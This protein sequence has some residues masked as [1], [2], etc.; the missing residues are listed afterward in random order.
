MKLSIAS[1]NSGSNGNCYY[2]GNQHEAVLIDAGISCRET[3]WRM[4]QIG[5]SINRV[6]AIFISHEHT[7]HTRG[8]EVLAR[9]YKIP[10]YFSDITYQNSRIKPDERFVH[11][12][13]SNIPVVIG[14]LTV[15][16]FPKR[17][18]ASDAHSFIVSGNEVHIGVF[19]DIGSVCENVKY[20]FNKCHAAFLEANYDEEMLE[21]GHYPYYLKTRIRSDYGHLSNIQALELF[22]N[23]SS[24]K[25]VHLFLSH[26]SKDNNSIELVSNLFKA[27][28]NKHTKVEIA[29]RF[30]QSKVCTIDAGILGREL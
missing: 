14:G 3:D 30:S 1:I 4:R 11:Y 24:E 5:L 19:T 27:V 29:S 18:D 16:G 21:N 8:V 20:N 22:K 25:L 15:T 23:H 17:H 12:F 28:A 7:D 26:I 10:V 2:V 13:Q 6:K 9:R